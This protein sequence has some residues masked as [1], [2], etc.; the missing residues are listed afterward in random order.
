MNRTVLFM[1]Y[2]NF[3]NQCCLF[4]IF[5]KTKNLKIKK[6]KTK[7]IVNL[8]L[9]PK[10]G[11][12]L[13]NFCLWDFMAP[14]ISSLFCTIFLGNISSFV[15]TDLGLQ[16]PLTILKKKWPSYLGTHCMSRHFVLLKHEKKI[17][18]W[19]G[20]HQLRALASRTVCFSGIRLAYINLQYF[21][22][23][24][25]WT[26]DWCSTP[27]SLFSFVFHVSPRWLILALDSLE[28]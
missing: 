25:K 11:S 2:Q 1:L 28:F 3:Q 22:F 9:N 15:T 16:A 21:F 8:A 12:N 24:S 5:F 6:K 4:Y 23:I 7:I 20:A 14:F 27:K 19:R 17:Q 13:Q 26:T 18:D 10:T